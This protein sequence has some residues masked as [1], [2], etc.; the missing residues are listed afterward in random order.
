VPWENQRYPVEKSAQ[1]FER[2]SIEGRS[3]AEWWEEMNHTAKTAATGQAFKEAVER[4]QHLLAR[5]EGNSIMLI[6]AAGAFR[7]YL[8]E[9]LTGVDWR[10]PKSEQKFE[11]F[12]SS[13]DR[14]KLPTE[15]EADQMNDPRRVEQFWQL[16]DKNAE[17]YK[18]AIEGAGYLLANRDG[19]IAV[20]TPEGVVDDLRRLT[21]AIAV[22]GED[23]SDYGH[24]I[25]PIDVQKLPTVQ[26]AQAIQDQRKGLDPELRVLLRNLDARQAREALDLTDKQELL[27]RDLGPPHPLDRYHLQE[28]EQQKDKFADERER[29]VSEYQESRRL[30]DEIRDREKQEALERGE[31]M[32]EGPGFSR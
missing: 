29:Y 7:T 21:P 31:G 3:F 22:K 16:A 5:A 2:D 9:S 10:D 4:D 20:V 14:A 25:A 13:I 28:R 27:T 19:K 8:S 15:H 1:D 23:I 32:E 26:E 18:R 24:F 6:S 30:L 12:V 11:N 17:T